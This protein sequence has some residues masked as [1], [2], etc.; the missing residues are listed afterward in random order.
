MKVGAVAS[1]PRQESGTSGVSNKRPRSPVSTP[2]ANR[3]QLR[4]GQV[5]EEVNRQNFQ[6]NGGHRKL[7]SVPTLYSNVKSILNKLLE[8]NKNVIIC[9]LTYPTH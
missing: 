2:Q 1:G 9:A 6:N 8:L 7:A 3:Q 4:G 5:R